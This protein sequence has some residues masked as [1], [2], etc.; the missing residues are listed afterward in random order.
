MLSHDA[1]CMRDSERATDWPNTET[2]YVCAQRFRIKHC[3]GG[4]IVETY[5]HNDNEAK[6]ERTTDFAVHSLI[7]ARIWVGAFN[8]I[9]FI[10]SFESKQYSGVCVAKWI[11]HVRLPHSSQSDAFLIIPK[12]A[13]EFVYNPG[14]EP[15]TVSH[16]F[17]AKSWNSGGI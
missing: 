5:R 2:M 3:D 15:K 9:F 4:Y 10:F 11:S 1:I 16:V 8:F 6:I 7:G 14:V 13:I 12:F 17:I